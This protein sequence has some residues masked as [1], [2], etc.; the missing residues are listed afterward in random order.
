[1]LIGTF[2]NVPIAA[3]DPLFMSHHAFVDYILEMWIR[4]FHG[5]YQPPAG[6]NSAAKGHNHDDV[7]VPFLPIFRV[8]EMLIESTELGWTYESLY[9][10]DLDKPYGC[11]YQPNDPKYK[12]LH[13]EKLKIQ[14]YIALNQ[15]NIL[16]SSTDYWKEEIYKVKIYWSRP[17]ARLSPFNLFAKL[18]QRGRKSPGMKLQNCHS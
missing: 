8:H 13:E 3:N 1:M 16:N 2:T 15:N 14:P 5:E 10:L 6:N 17:L 4:R 7:I 11:E 9:G 18:K 12:S